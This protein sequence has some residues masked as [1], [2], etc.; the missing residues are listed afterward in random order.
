MKNYSSDFEAYVYE[1]MMPLKSEINGD[2]YRNGMR[3]FNSNKEDIVVAF[4]TGLDGQFQQATVNVNI[5]VPDI[6]FNGRYTK[7]IGRLA[8]LENALKDYLNSIKTNNYLISL[9]M[10]PVILEGDANEH[11]INCR[12]NL[13]YNSL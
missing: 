8:T 3:P 9:D 5:Y 1:L 7:D 12:L 13:T 10:L 11:F 4:L 6:N 2:L